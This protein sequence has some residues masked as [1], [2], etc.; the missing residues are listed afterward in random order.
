MSETHVRGGAVA[1]EGV[2]VA[3]ADQNH[4]RHPESG[5]AAGERPDV[6]PLRYIVNNHVALVYL[7]LLLTLLLHVDSY[8]RRFG[9]SGAVD[10]KGFRGVTRL[11]TCDVVC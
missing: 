5:S 10:V 4:L 6:V 7:T 1:A 9:G 11:T 8:H 2:E 3:A